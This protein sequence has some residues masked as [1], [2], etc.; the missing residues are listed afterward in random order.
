MKNRRPC[1]CIA[2]F[3]GSLLLDPGVKTEAQVKRTVTSK[4]LTLGVV[5][6]SA[7]EPVAKQFRP[8]AEYT[9]RKLAPGGEIKGIVIVA[10][11]I[12]RLIE[13]IGRAEIDF[14][15]ES[16]FPT[17]LVNRSGIGKII[18]RRWKGGRDEYRGVIFRRKERRIDR[19]EDLRG[20]II[21]F[22]DAGSTSGYFL[23]KLLLLEKKFQVTERPSLSAKV[24]GSEIGY[25]FAGSEKSVV[26]LVREGKVAAGAISDDDYAHLDETSKAGLAVLVESASLPR[27]LLSVRASLPEAVTKL[28]KEILLSMHQNSE[29]ENILRQTDGTTKFDTLPG[30]E[31]AFRRKLND[32]YGLRG[33]KK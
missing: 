30:G 33:E 7:P 6:H 2:V 8:L 20:K 17:Y 29:G 24:S 21:A 16:P 19:L 13:L 5:H 12:A 31:E 23:P 11:N 14:Y 1:V 25:V 3:I 4:T 10:E 18:L 9:S 15:L 27:H 32:L 26:Q 28:I 22:E